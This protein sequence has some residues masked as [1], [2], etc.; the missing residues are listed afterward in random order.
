MSGNT[1][2]AR[3]LRDAYALPT[4]LRRIAVTLPINERRDILEHAAEE[5]E[6]L[7][8]TVAS[9]MLSEGKE[10]GNG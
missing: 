5:L 3:D 6:A 4:E 8:K 9:E 7:Q 10:A 2:R 1:V